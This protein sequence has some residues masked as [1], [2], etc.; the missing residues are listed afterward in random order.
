MKTNQKIKEGSTLK[1][2][3]INSIPVVIGGILLTIIGSFINWQIEKSKIKNS[4]VI[5]F[6]KI[7]AQKIGESWAELNELEAQISILLEL[8]KRTSDNYKK[9]KTSPSIQ[10]STMILALLNKTMGYEKLFKIERNRFWI[11]EEQYQLMGEFGLL[12]TRKQDNYLKFNQD[13]I[14][15]LNKMIHQKREHLESV[16]SKMLK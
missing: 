8:D 4:F 6:N 3:L 5:E 7:K 15:I 14:I 1:T 16:I 11:G 13:S 12:V 10:D 9:Y 2:G